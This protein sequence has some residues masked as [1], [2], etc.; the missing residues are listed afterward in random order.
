MMSRFEWLEM[1]QGKPEARA[2]GE[3]GPAD[4]GP[5]GRALDETHFLAV[6][7]ENLARGQYETALRNY[8]K[9]LHFDLRIEKAWIGQV[10]CLTE[11][12]EYHEAITWTDK[13]L[14]YFPASSEIT[15]LKAVA[16][17]RVGDTERAVAFSDASLKTDR[18][19]PL[20]WWARGDVLLGSNPRNAEYCFRKAA[21]AG[22]DWAL[23][24]RIGKSL[25][26][27]DQP[28]KARERLQQA[29]ALNPD[30][31]LPWYWLGITYR[32]LA[33]H[34]EASKCLERALELQP[35]NAETQKAL[36]ELKRVG[37]A[38]R[39]AERIRLRLKG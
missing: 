26:S 39:W 4:P 8:S 9:A 15:A 12:G 18:T 19:R 16:W 36:F 31:P 30:H 37:F 23:L 21:E 33:M 2:Q 5:G 10:L 1:P 13:A 35:S 29:R 38:R 14:E 34:A 17:G 25:L 6:A 20:V 7:D 28:L 3:T 27:V 24:V 22:R 11:L 32:R